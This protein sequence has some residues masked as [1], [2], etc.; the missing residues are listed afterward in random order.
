MT[1]TGKGNARVDVTLRPN[2]STFTE[3]PVVRASGGGMVL[4]HVSVVRRA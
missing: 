4:C 2:C 1:R 3:E